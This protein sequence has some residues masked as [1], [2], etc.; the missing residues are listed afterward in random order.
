MKL[1]NISSKEITFLNILFNIEYELTALDNEQGKVFR[2]LI[3]ELD[4]VFLAKA[5]LY[6]RNK[7]KLKQLSYI[8]IVMLSPRISGKK[9]AKDY[10]YNLIDRPNDLIKIIKCFEIYNYK[11]PNALKKGFYKA[12]DKFDDLQLLMSDNNINKVLKLIHPKSNQTNEKALRLISKNE[13][14]NIT[15]FI[16]ENQIETLQAI[17]NIKI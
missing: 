10:Y 16:N 9:W 4:P 3:L 14:S 1:E 8:I 7:L 15:T 5:S 12:F 11:L 6:V 2:K 17:N 13:C